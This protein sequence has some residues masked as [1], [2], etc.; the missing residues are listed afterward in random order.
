MRE[1]TAAGQ[2]RDMTS[3]SA[4]AEAGEGL[5]TM[6]AQISDSVVYRGRT[7]TLA[8]INGT[9][10]FE[11]SQHGFRP[12]SLSTDCRRG[13]YCTY[14]VV[15]ASL[16]LK[17]AYI[18]LGQQPRGLFGIPSEYDPSESLHSFR[19]LH[20]PVPFTGTLLLAGGLLRDLTVNMGFH[21]AWK[22]SEVHEL[23]VENGQVLCAEDR[24]AHMAEARALLSV[25]PLRP[26]D[27]R[28]NQEVAEWVS[29][30]FRLDD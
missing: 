6:T 27:P 2:Q 22:F 30:C 20:A 17:D 11:P 13:F 1:R 4:F 15:D 16:R 21:P 5:A 26:K 23:L 29:R 25:L 8:G 14:E 19:E 10:L 12:L 24:S 9:G 28:D 7:F 18:V 3:S